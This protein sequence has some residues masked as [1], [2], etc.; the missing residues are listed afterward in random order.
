MSYVSQLTGRFYSTVDEMTLA[1][2]QE[3]N[4]LRAINEVNPLDDMSADQIEAAFAKAALSKQEK[5]AAADREYAAQLFVADHPEFVLNER[6]SNAIYTVLELQGLSGTTP[7][8]IEQAFHEAQR[9]GLVE[10]QDVPEEQKPRHRGD[11]G[12]F[13]ATPFKSSLP[14]LSE[15]EMYKL[16]YAELEKRARVDA[17]ERAT[18][19]LRPPVPKFQ[20]APEQQAQP[21]RRRSSGISSRGSSPGQVA[22]KKLTEADLYNLSYDDL[23]RGSR[24]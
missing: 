23:E 18:H 2:G 12:Q 19:A 3:L 22:A 5:F 21:E 8:E 7:E 17:L 20:H 11:N 14:D 15:E 6:N 13:A 4:R 10:V 9:R 16:P 1:D 24:Q